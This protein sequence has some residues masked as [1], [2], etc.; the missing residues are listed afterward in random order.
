MTGRQLSAKLIALDIISHYAA[1]RVLGISRSSIIRYV[2]GHTV[3]PLHVER[4]L[5]MLERYGIPKEW[6]DA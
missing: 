1:Q 4:Y 2:H 3:I 5:L 6:R